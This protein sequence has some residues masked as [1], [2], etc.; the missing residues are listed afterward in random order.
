M[1]YR[2]PFIVELGVRARKTLGVPGMSC[3]SG[4]AAGGP[5]ESCLTGA[6]AGWTVTPCV[7]AGGF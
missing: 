7:P 2:K 4:P 6:G 5:Y 3:V 1:P